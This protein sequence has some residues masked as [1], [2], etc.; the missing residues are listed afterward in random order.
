[1]ELPS[2]CGINLSLAQPLIKGYCLNFNIEYLE[3]QELTNTGVH[4]IGAFLKGKLIAVVGLFVSDTAPNTLYVYGIYGN[5]GHNQA[6]GIRALIEFVNL[7]PYNEKYG[8]ILRANS[9]M[10]RILS[11]VGWHISEFGPE[12]HKVVCNGVKAQ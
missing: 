5:L 11:R 6:R 4:W 2:L 9:K 3:E 8:Y 10:L 12:F 7:L 1:M